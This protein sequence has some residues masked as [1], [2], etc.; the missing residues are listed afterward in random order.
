MYIAVLG[1]VI[2]L[3]ECGKCMPFIEINNM[4]CSDYYIQI[5][6]SSQNSRTKWICLI[7]RL[8]LFSAFLLWWCS[9][10]LSYIVGYCIPV[11]FHLS[12]SG[13]F[14]WLT[15]QYFSDERISILLAF[16]SLIAVKRQRHLLRNSAKCT[17]W[18][19][20]L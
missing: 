16:G 20:E 2:V 3:Q 12:G 13:S 9:S 10:I 4:S 6:C 17:T 1:L 5:T 19:S 14:G 11:T 15:L 7:V 8:Y 18:S